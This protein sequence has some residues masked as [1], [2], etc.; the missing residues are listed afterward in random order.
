MFKALSRVRTETTTQL[1]FVFCNFLTN[2]KKKTTV[3]IF[4]TSSPSIFSATKEE[5]KGKELPASYLGEWRQ[6]R[7]CRKWKKSSSPGAEM[8]TFLLY[9]S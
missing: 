4:I 5:S 3:T 2:Q 7:A 6:R 9:E 8:L 1:K